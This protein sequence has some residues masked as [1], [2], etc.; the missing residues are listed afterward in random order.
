MKKA[1]FTFL[2]ALMLTVFVNQAFAQVPQGFNY[3]AVARNSV[4]VLLNNQALGV[5]LAIHQGS[6]GGTVVYSERQTPT[7]NAF[8]LFTVTVGQGTVLTGTFTTINWASG[9]YWL[10]VGLDVTGGTTYT[11][12][13]TSQLLSV[14]YAMYAGTSGTAGA[15]GPTGPTGPTGAAGATGATGAIGPIGPTGL[16]GATGPLV[17]GT[18]GQ[19]LRNNG[20]T[21]VATSNLYN[22]GTY[23]GFGTTTPTYPVDILHTGST[24]LRVASSSSFSV[25]DIDANSGDAALRFARAGV[26]QWNLRNHPT[27]DDL[28][29]FELGGGGSRIT[30]QNATG[31]FGIGT[32]TPSEKLSVAGNGTFSGQIISTVATGTAPFSILSTDVNTNLNADMID[33]QHYSANWGLWTDNGLYINPTENTNLKIYDDVVG[34]IG[35]TYV[36]N[37]NTDAITNWTK[38]TI[39]TLLNWD[40]AG[41]TYGYYGI[42]GMYGA[43]GSAS[44]YGIFGQNSANSLINGHLGGTAYGAYG[45][46]SANTKGYLGSSSYGAYGQYDATHF[47]FFGSASYG[48]YAQ[49]SA[50]EIM[51]LGYS[52]TQA[53]YSYHNQLLASGDGQASMFAYRTRDAQNDGTGYSQSTINSAVKGYSF[54]G[55]LYSFG[56][57]GF[58]YNDYNRCGGTL[59]ADVNGFYWG[60]LGYRSSGLANYGGYF[61]SSINGTGFMPS[62]ATAGIGSASYGDLMGSWSRGE[63]FGTAASGEVFASYNLG[64]EYTSGY[65]ADIITTGDKKVAAYGVTSTDLKVYNDGSAQL[66]NGTC[67]VEFQNDF[68]SVISGKPIVTVTPS[69]ECNGLYVVSV[70][71]KGFT[72]KEMNSGNSSVE[73]SYIVIGKRIDAQSNNV[74]SMITD[75]NF[76]KNLKGMMFNENNKDRN[77]SPFWWDGSKLRTDAVP[78]QKINKEEKMRNE[79]NP[80]V[81]MEVKPVDIS[82]TPKGNT[83]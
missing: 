61:T 22:D 13:G 20:T 30:L 35:M 9:N 33:G 62:G 40:N 83:K 5:R 12:M 74:P 3:Q 19:T 79:Q 68:A 57:S 4:G 70:D 41:T 45:Q 42:G 71:S 28:E 48:A 75:V 53:N 76:D 31:N 34:Y 36:G 65:Q 63:M 24:G 73:F 77:A 55:D 11:A 69:G 37:T 25:I 32:Q 23:V 8:G 66:S 14:P 38:G 26:N 47:G 59:G 21:W 2:G 44:S 52:A 72:V 78:Q 58:N 18:T 49:R 29:I 16:T 51:Y 46:Y 10:E 82:K 56:T 17:P 64:N 15:T 39:Q 60:S 1:I 80:Q 67:R 27:T 81:Q 43:F 7:T 54:W 6:S 50:N